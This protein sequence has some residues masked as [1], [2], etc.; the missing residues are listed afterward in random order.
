VRF[1]PFLAAT[2]I[3]L[4]PGTY[5]MTFAGREGVDWLMAQEIEVVAGTVVFVA[6][7]VGVRLWWRRRKGLALKAHATS[8]TE[9]NRVDRKVPNQPEGIKE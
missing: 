8:H 1:L 3:G 4:A 6:V 7:L 2:I 5:V 9:T